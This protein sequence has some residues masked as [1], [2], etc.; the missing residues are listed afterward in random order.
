MDINKYIGEKI[1]K[2]RMEKN[3]TQEE[4]GEYL[5]TTSQTISRYESGKLGTNQDVLYKL[6]QYFK[7]SI[8][9]FFPNIEGVG[10][11]IIN[12]E[13]GTQYISTVQLSI[14]SGVSI[15]DINDIING[16]NVIPK[17]T[18][19]AKIAKAL[20]NDLYDYLI[21]FGYIEDPEDLTNTLFNTGIRYLLEK[22]ERVFMCQYLSSYWNAQSVT[23][24]FTI[25]EIY[26][27]LFSNEDTLTKEEINI[28]YDRIKNNN[29]FYLTI[30]EIRNA[31]VH[32]EKKVITIDELKQMIKYVEKISDDDKK[33][34][35]SMLDYFAQ[36]KL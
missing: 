36:N 3:I 30:S 32:N 28:S 20:N 19:L 6:A 18:I 11:D 14:L 29:D 24:V 26:Q 4:L 17:P 21:S 1:K 2:Y 34:L 25:E 16:E 23:D 22:K 35:I 27:T 8:N 7:I 15:K 9:N 13:M 5:N 10:S 33:T 12:D 31:I